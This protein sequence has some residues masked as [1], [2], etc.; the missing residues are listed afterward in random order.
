ME[1]RNFYTDHPITGD[2][3]NPDLLNRE[4]YA[5]QIGHSIIVAPG[6][7][8]LVVSIEGSWGYGKT[9]VMNLIKK[10]FRSQ[11]KKTRPIIVDF[12]PWL[13]GNAENL[14][15][16]FLIQFASEIGIADRGKELKG[17]AKQVLAYSKIFTVLKLIPGAGQYA[18]LV[19]KVFEKVGEAG[20]NIGE[21]KEL[22]FNEKRKNV[23]ESL[24][25]I[26]NPIVVFID[27]LD[28][29]LPAEVFQMLRVIK[30]IA[31]FPSTTYIL[32][33]EST[34]IEQALDQHG[35]KNTS[36][37]LDKIVQCRF[38]LPKIN[39]LDL[40]N[41]FEKEFERSLTGELQESFDRD[42]ENFI[43]LYCTAVKPILKSPR[44]IKRILNKLKMVAPV[45]H[46][47]V[48]FS[49][50]FGLE[51]L[52]IKAPA[53]YEHIHSEPVAYTG[54]PLGETFTFD[55][56]KEYAEKFKKVREEKIKKSQECDR[57]YIEKIIYHLFP[58]TDSAGFNLSHPTYGRVASTDR[59][60][61][62]LSYGLPTE[63]V[64]DYDV[65]EYLQNPKRRD[66]IADKIIQQGKL[67]RFLELL[68]RRMMIL[69][70]K[71]AKFFCKNWEIS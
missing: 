55:P 24:K 25:R 54:I 28:R 18:E 67:D 46:R 3:N 35:I 17:V 49:D 11:E 65:R 30:A 14:A 39:E 68:M 50:I 58:L 13:I 8:G 34:Y 15:Q 42:R 23:L 9:S 56:P 40:H 71:I 59:L 21:L 2:D 20:K 52:A 51:V 47:E 69:F 12:N 4:E 48:A 33:F 45:I 16:E 70:L 44:E 37:Y 7:D 41:I 64:A 5:R 27:D 61:I 36:L 43:D 60:M 19:E 1:D 22:N 38:H 31:D 6:S 57:K 29:L 26:K 63:E 10:S 32:G 66:E 62:A 53:V